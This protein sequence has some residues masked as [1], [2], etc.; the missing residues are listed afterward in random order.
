MQTLRRTHALLPGLAWVSADLSGSPEHCG[1][2]DGR[3]EIKDSF[4]DGLTIVAPGSKKG[5]GT[6]LEV[7]V[8]TVTIF[9]CGLGVWNRHGLLINE[10]VSETL[11]LINS[12]I[13][14]TQND[15][16]QFTIVRV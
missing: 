3:L 7:R 4:S 5:Q 13:A 11:M 1:S 16:P 2:H 10:G 15:S 14:D 8:E 9:N 12:K 6:L